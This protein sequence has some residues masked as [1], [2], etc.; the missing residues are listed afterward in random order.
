M[1]AIAILTMSVPV[2]RGRRNSVDDAGENETID[3]DA[4]R[5]EDAQECKEQD[6]GDQCGARELGANV[7]EGGE[8]YGKGEEEEH[9][10]VVRIVEGGRDQGAAD[11]GLGSEPRPGQMVPCQQLPHAD[12]GGEDGGRHPPA[13][14]PAEGVA[15]PAFEVGDGQ[16]CKES[17]ADRER[18]AER[19]ILISGPEDTKESPHEPQAADDE[20]DPHEAVPGPRESGEEGNG[21]EGDG[22]HGHAIGKEVDAQGL[23]AAEMRP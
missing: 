1:P 12:G 19:V 21:R 8:E 14:E 5:G 16:E 11:T 7:L 22:Q 10:E 20:V 13:N 6:Q 3:R 23:D 15:L 9:A 4:T 18:T 17:E 2:R